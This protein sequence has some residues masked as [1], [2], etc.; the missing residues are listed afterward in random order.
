MEILIIPTVLF[1]FFVWLLFAYT[2]KFLTFLAVAFFLWV[3]VVV[4]T[5]YEDE[6]A[7]FENSQ[8]EQQQDG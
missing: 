3:F 8:A 1:I 5:A 4:M 2:K 7:A 6:Q